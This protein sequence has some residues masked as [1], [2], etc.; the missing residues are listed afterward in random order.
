MMQPVKMKT[1]AATIRA[2]AH[3]RAYLAK[4][5]VFMLPPKIVCCCRI[6]IELP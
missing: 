3:S 5:R 6:A 2:L 4:L 1:S